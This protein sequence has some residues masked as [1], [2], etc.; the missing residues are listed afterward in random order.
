LDFLAVAVVRF[1]FMATLEQNSVFSRRRREIGSSVDM[2]GL[3]LND[4]N[5]TNDL[6]T[7]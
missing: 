2:M 7:F 5:S 1:S 3:W 4:A 6:H